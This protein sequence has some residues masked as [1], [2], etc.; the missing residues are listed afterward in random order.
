MSGLF[1]SSDGN[2]TLATA[3]NAGEL[4]SANGQF[5]N[6]STF[7]S[8][9]VSS[10]IPSD[11]L[12]DVG[13]VEVT[14][15]DGTVIFAQSSDALA[16]VNLSAG[17]ADNT[18]FDPIDIF[19]I[20][21][22]PNVELVFLETSISPR[23]TQQGPNQ[24]GVLS[25]RFSLTVETSGVFESSTRVF[26]VRYGLEALSSDQLID[27]SSL[28]LAFA[29]LLPNA[30]LTDQ[31]VLNGLL[32]ITLGLL[33]GDFTGPDAS[34]ELVSRLNFLDAFVALNNIE[35]R[36][37]LEETLSFV[38][39]VAVDFFRPAIF[40]DGNPA[41]FETFD[42]VFFPESGLGIVSFT[43]F[44]SE[45]SLQN[46]SDGTVDA[47]VIS[48]PVPFISIPTVLVFENPQVASSIITGTEL[49]DVLEGDAGNNTILGL[50][51][52]DVLIGGPGEDVLNGV[53]G[54]D[55]VS[56]EVSPEGVIV[57][58]ILGQGFGGEAE[59]DTFVSIENLT[60]SALDDIFIASDDDIANVFN[61]GAGNDVF[62]SFGGDDVL[63]GGDGNDLLLGGLGD[64]IING[65]GGDD[66]LEGN[67]NND[68]INGGTGA[69]TILGQ[70]GNDLLN[71]EAGNDVIL[72]GDDDDTIDGGADNDVILGGK[73]VNDIT[74]GLGNDLLLGG[75]SVDTVD[76]GA[77]N[78]VIETNGGNDF[79]MAGD[80][81]NIVLAGDGDDMVT[82]GSG[83]DALAGGD[84]ND[85]L[86]G[87]DGADTLVGGAGNDTLIGG[88]GDDQIIAVAGANTLDG[89]AGADFLLGGELG[90]MLDGGAGNDFINGL[91]GND[92]LMGGAGSDTLVGEAGADTFVFSAGIDSENVIDFADD[93]DMLDLTAFNFASVTAALDVA[94]ETADGGVFFDFSNGDTAL[95]NNITEAQLSDDILV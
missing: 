44:N 4:G 63:N 25:E 7:L 29:T 11:E 27:F 28:P 23:L 32:E 77:G 2:D 10:F 84:G 15:P 76:G 75:N 79:V 74:G 49:N 91:T 21:I 61:G 83:V 41:D 40:I 87:G 9:T 17:L 26:E 48:R 13:T 8:G 3:V 59:G 16:L 80:G 14:R 39:E 64:D 35:N 54:S 19:A 72:G 1:V 81:M 34:Q 66:I 31:D 24:T 51:G 46:N 53:S 60:G 38:R 36:V 18:S 12:N 42:T 43:G 78:D 85:T 90:D 30:Q 88:A 65:D 56:F 58:L 73:G 20:E 22:Q 71:G 95:I 69:D 86:D 6:S 67:G 93:E 55:T 37:F 45:F 33:L 57:N 47:S 89:G 68:V 92:I 94:V 62:L 52:D 70:G 5:I 50:A 82:S